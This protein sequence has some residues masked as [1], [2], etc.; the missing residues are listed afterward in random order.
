MKTRNYVLLAFLLAFGASANGQMLDD[1]QFS[2]GHDPSL[3][4]TLDS[5][6]NLLVDGSVYYRRSYIENIGFDFPFADTSYSQFSV[7]LAGVLRLGGTRALTTSGYQGSPFHPS[8]LNK[9]LPKIVFFGCS[10]YVSDSAYVHFQTF[11]TAPERVLVV[12]F[13][14][15]TYSTSSRHSLLRWQVQMFES[16][17]IQIVYPSRQ[18]PILPAGNHQQGLCTDASDVWIVDQYHTAT[19]YTSGC[20][21][22]IPGGNWPDINRY[23]RFA[24][25]VDVCPSP[26]HLV[27]ASVDT[28]SVTLSW[29]GDGGIPAYAV[30][31]APVQF[32]P[33]TGAGTLLTVS[34][35]FATIG[36]LQAGTQYYFYVRSVCDAADTSNAAHIAVRTLTVVPVSELP[37]FCDFESAAER[38]SWLTPRGNLDTW[39]WTGTA[40]N[41]TQPGQYALYISQDSGT[42]NTGG[43]QWVGAYAYRDFN[44]EA[45]DWL[46]GFDWRAYGDWTSNAGVDYYYH[47]LRAFLVPASVN[48]TVQTPASFP[49]SPHTTAVPAGWIDLN[50][51]GHLFCGQSGWTSH[52]AA[53]SVPSAGCYHLVFYWETDG[54]AP[55]T[56][57]PAAIDNISLE[58]ISCP[59]PQQLAATA[60]ED[61]I[62][63]SWHRG[64]SETLWAVRYGTVEA[65]T[66]DTFYLATDLNFNTEYTFQVA[67]VCGEGDTSL[68]ITGTFS[69]LAGGPVTTIPYFC[70]FEDSLA[71]RQ[72]I[73]NGTGQ[74]NRWYVGT[75]ANNTPQG[76]RALYVS[77]DGGATNTYS[78][79]A[80]N[81]SYAYRTIVLDAAHYACTFDWR[82]QGDDDFHFLRAFIV[83]ANALPEAGSYPVSNDHYSSV[84]TGW[85]DLNPQGHY[86]SGQSDWT[87]QMGTFEVTDS[88]L[89]ALLFM[90][91]NDD[92]TPNNPPAA[93]DNISIEPILCPIPTGLDADAMQ[94]MI[95]LTWDAGSDAQQWL[96]TYADT[97]VVTYIS[98]YTATGLTPNTPYVF[99]V[100]TM[101][102]TGDTSIAATIAVRTSCLPITT[103]PYTY[104]FEDCVEGIGSG[105]EFVPCWN[106]LRNYSSFYPQVSSNGPGG[107]KS[108]YWNLTAGL[109]D[110]V[111][112]TLPELDE[113]INATYTE[114][115]FKAVKIDYFNMM[116]DPVFVIGVM[117]DPTN[118][119]SFEAVDTVTV[120]GTG[121]Y[122][123]FSVPLLAYSGTGRFVAIRGIVNGDSYASAMSY[124]D[125]V[126]LHELQYCRK[127]V[128]IALGAGIDTVAVS[129]TAGG[130][131]T[132]WLLAY[133][134]TTVTTQQPL[135]VAR[136]LEADREY[137]F[138]VAAIC[139]EGDT[140][141]M[142]TGRCRTLPRPQD[143]PDTNDTALCPTVTGLYYTQDVLWEDNTY[144]FTFHWDDS[145][146]VYEIRIKNL[147]FPGMVFNATTTSTS[148][149]FNADGIGGEWTA[150]VRAVCNDTVWG[151]WS[152]S[153]MFVTPIC[154]DIDAMAESAHVTI[155]PNPAN[156][157]AT[158][159]LNGISGTAEVSVVDLTG[160]TVMTRNIEC[161]AATSTLPLEGL[162]AG[163]YFVRVS[164]QGLNTVRKLIVK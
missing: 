125:D 67:A 32:T 83:P 41:N 143:P 133:G 99:S 150:A 31:Y 103:L 149:F 96:V 87:T 81:P 134:D 25:P 152:D 109:L 6:R 38:N 21:T 48:F 50:P 115:R 61:E 28:A 160:K 101:C 124:L 79:A 45:G 69:T 140:S 73:L 114:L 108:L 123:S 33:G 161:T 66:Q 85:I 104:G 131:E 102:Y 75:A 77:Q 107:G 47:F 110:N 119:S 126:E 62:M 97:A 100:S 74:T 17:D 91:E 116:D 95:D 121:S 27:A 153:V 144:K 113:S 46:V 57:L 15:Q 157:H 158:L 39:W 151:E 37:Y 49:S 58:H 3:W 10:G 24:F 145:A 130:S 132:Q 71:N 56:D 162:A 26:Q 63:L 43:D 142:L 92:Y 86:M 60:T 164:A 155:Y 53:V 22:L 55:G 112:I 30:E 154:I 5:T 93:V 147:H 138:A 16:G 42:T 19:H 2:T 89:Y 106:R 68:A 54:Y 11:G 14:L 122:S 88:G 23:Y 4:Y 156:G 51:Q 18:P 44:L 120:T 127:P 29:R 137:L 64:G 129:W 80:F 65:Y 35:T 159:S 13:A 128:G 52:S 76:Q 90:W 139:G 12:E 34:D 98:S 111:I 20:S 141:E 163:T 70:D 105:E 146:D 59:Q 148:Y 136:G 118:E 94:T 1:Y 8:N 78:G 36:G 72:W 135:Y 9:N 82:C 117:S 84:P 40:A 7:T